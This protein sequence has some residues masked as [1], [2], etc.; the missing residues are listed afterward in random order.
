[1]LG[2]PCMPAG[3]R[4]GQFEFDPR[5]RELRKA[6]LRLRVPDQSLEI[7][8]ML[9][10][11]PG[12]V[13]LR[14][15]IRERLWPNGTIVEFEHSVSVA[16]GRLRE[17]LAD[18]ADTPRFVETVPRRGYRFLA[19]VEAL[20]PDGP[21]PHYRI[22][23]EAGRGAMGVVYEAEDLTLR[24]RVALK[25]LPEELAS[26]PP[27]LERFRHEARSLAAL[28]HPGV[29]TI[30]GIEEHDGRPC[31]IMEYLEGRPLSRLIEGSPLKLAQVLD[32]AIQIA[33]ALAAAHQA[34]IVHRDLK[35]ANIMLG[36]DGRVKILD[37]GLAKLVAP[38]PDDGLDSTQTMKAQT[39][40]GVIAG[41]VAYMSPEQAEGKSV[42]PRSDIFSFGSVLYELTTGRQAFSAGS[43][44]S[45]LSA[46]LRG[47]PEPLVGAPQQLQALIARC[48]KKD[49][50]L[51]YQHMDEV[52]IAL[53]ELKE[54][55]GSGK[56][57]VARPAVR[58]KSRRWRLA[59]TATLV[60]AATLAALGWFWLGR[61]RPATPEAPLTIVPLT[62]YPGGEYWPSFSPDGNEVAFFWNGNIYVKQ[63]NVEPPVQLTTD[64]AGGGSPAWSPDGRTIAFLRGLSPRKD[65]IMLIPQRGGQ[66]RVLAE[67]NLPNNVLPIS[68]ASLAWTPDSKWL[69]CPV[70]EAG[71]QYWALYL[72]SV[73]T[74]ERRRVTKPPS[75]IV[76]D[77]A[78][79]F[80]P[81]GSSLVFARET[82]TWNF[83]NLYL[84]HLAQDYSPLGDPDRIVLDTPFNTDVVW[85][86]NGREIVFVSGTYSDSGLWRMTVSSPATRKRLA[87][88]PSGILTPA[89]SKQGNRLAYALI[90]WDPNIWRVD[91]H[92]PGRKPGVAVPFI[93]S[94]K[95]EF[96]PAYSPD[97]KRIAFASDRAGTSEIWIC[98]SDGSKAAKLTSFGGANVYGPRWSW[99]NKS[100]AF[101]VGQKD[102]G[103]DVYVIGAS[104]GVPHRL[105]AH[106]AND[107]WSYWSRNGQWIYFASERT[108]QSE[109]WKMPAGGGETGGGEAIQITRNG[110]GMPQESPDGKSLYYDKGWP[111]PLSVW[112]M[113]IE[114][115]EEAKVLDSVHHMGQWEI[116]NEGIYY[117][118]WPDDKGHSDIQTRIINGTS[119]LGLSR[120]SRRRNDRRSARR[121]AGWPL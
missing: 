48:L 40:E 51:R 27:A 57:V 86:P 70:P 95:W 47:E 81:D 37:F 12:E 25:Y 87:F 11:R 46:I 106:P 101:T 111:A 18:S 74:G 107:L 42:D 103:E 21:A 49:P 82:D 80:S 32:I 78:P 121:P 96:M 62:S 76:G 24:R 8:A 28:N 41:T 10:E 69:A 119:R 33:G 99:D 26:H 118:R 75:G 109:I 9:L 65:A 50:Q 38:V 71:Q 60:A 3:L 54:G 7:L 30:H 1:M 94:T 13:V 112:R 102:I 53:E 31:L 43:K 59:A 105:T 5:T 39:E 98:D 35:P 120:S 64:P 91:L 14:E 115:G 92:G 45:T 89:V 44:I 110:G 56:L 58:K 116:V 20:Q 29:C 113:P 15:A 68:K 19:P 36:K 4:F 66:E 93:S 22:L 16:V 90:R 83:S 72:F 52:K 67:I 114:G 79:A 34:G 100:I 2:L 88:A 117:F 108:G 55:L 63:I 6:G 77:T 85:M 23:R 61:S 84:L 17:A 73:E 97:G 104:G